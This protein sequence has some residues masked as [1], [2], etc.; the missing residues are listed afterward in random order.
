MESSAL[1]RSYSPGHMMRPIALHITT[2][3]ASVPG[4]P[5]APLIYLARFATDP[6]TRPGYGRDEADAIVD[7]LRANRPAAEARPGLRPT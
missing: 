3:R 4:D 2:M 1:N 6:Y 7:L 5:V